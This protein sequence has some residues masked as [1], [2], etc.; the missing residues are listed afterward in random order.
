MAGL[1]EGVA[2]PDITR[3]TTT[4]AE[5]PQYLTD[6]LTN[7]AQVGTSQLGKATPAVKDAQGNVITPGSFSAKTGAEL[8]AD[9]PDYF[10]N[11]VKGTG[12]NQA[13]L[14]NLSN[15]SRY[16]TALDE[17]LRVGQ[18]ASKPIGVSY[19]AQGKPIFSDTLRAFYDP[20]QQNVID[21]MQK[22]SDINVQRNV[23]PGLKALGASTGQFGGSRIGN[24]GGQALADIASN[25][26]TQQTAA[27]SAGYKTALDAA[28]KQQGNQ[29]AVAG[30]LGNIG[31]TESAATTSALKQLADMGALDTAY[32]QAEIDAPLTRAA[33]VAQLLRGYA[34][35]TTT[36]ENYKGPGSVYGPSVFQ[37]IAGLGS[38]VGALFPSGGGGAGTQLINRLFGSGGNNTTGSD[39]DPRNLPPWTDY[40]TPPPE[41]QN[42]EAWTQHWDYGD[43]GGE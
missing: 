42:W 40:S 16:E 6:Y 2:P 24:I 9:R 30:A 26:Q 20:Y 41:I 15:L 7:L 34:Y 29:A 4:K 25:L 1:F 11:L 5:A 36:T 39:A 12:V 28:L 21:E 22:Q 33:N 35:P 19:D 17:A 3:T 10:S 43:G 31:G 23:L 32:S 37:Q 8:I 27:R 13:E 18:Q 14:P 38:L